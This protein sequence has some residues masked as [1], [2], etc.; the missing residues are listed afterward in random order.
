MAAALTRTWK[1][2]ASSIGNYIR[3]ENAQRIGLLP[4]DLDPAKFRFLGNTALAGA[5]CAALSTGCRRSAS[6][7]ARRAAHVDLSLDQD[8]QNIYVQ[9]MFFPE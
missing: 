4:H 7:F 1:P 3:C 6:Q 5:R 2:R 9:A 8:F